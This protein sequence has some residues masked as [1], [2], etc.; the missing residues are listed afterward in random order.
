M[1]V[2]PL[3]LRLPRRADGDLRYET[4]E[5]AENCI[6]YVN[7]CRLDDRIIRTDWDTGFE[8]GRQ[9]GRGRSGGQVC[10]MLFSAGGGNLVVV[11]FVA[12]SEPVY[13]M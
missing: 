8:E 12:L 5:A 1:C 13:T 11:A 9:Y 7:T 6:R 4:R 3:P 10:V 2:R